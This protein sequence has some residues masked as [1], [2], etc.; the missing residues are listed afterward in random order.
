MHDSGLE[1]AEMNAASKV[2]QEFHSFLAEHRDSES[3]RVFD[4]LLNFIAHTVGDGHPFPYWFP[5]Y[6][7]NTKIPAAAY[8]LDSIYRKNG[9]EQL[10][11]VFS[12]CGIQNALSYQLLMTD[13]GLCLHTVSIQELLIQQDQDGDYDF[14]WIVETYYF[15]NSKSWLAYVSH[16][17]TIS[18]A[19]EQIVSAA[20]QSLSDSFLFPTRSNCLASPD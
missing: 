18:F 19:G 2:I 3:A 14:P 15:D 8:N 5:L 4:A 6:S 20:K 12:K 7:L 16:E 9:I 1:A 17:G 13:G 11:Q 10:Q